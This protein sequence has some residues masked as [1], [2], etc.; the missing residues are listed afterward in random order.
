MM[1][2]KLHINILTL[3]SVYAILIV[4]P[5]VLRCSDCFS[6]WLI[7]EPGIDLHFIAQ[8]AAQSLSRLDP[9]NLTKE[10]ELT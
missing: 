3:L 2:T 6:S 4:Q 10:S 1:Y 8:P 7:S 5:G 9:L